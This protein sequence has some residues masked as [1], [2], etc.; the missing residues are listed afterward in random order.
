MKDQF[1]SIDNNKNGKVDIGELRTA[2]KGNGMK[3][4][5]DQI[6]N[7]LKAADAN[8]DGNVNFDEFKALV[9]DQG[10]A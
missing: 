6:K 2:L 10:G 8:N 3:I 7:M 9:K 4:P 1:K 5:D